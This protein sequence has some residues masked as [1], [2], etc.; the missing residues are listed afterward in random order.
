M[1][2][3]TAGAGTPPTPKRL[4]DDRS[5]PSTEFHRSLLVAHFQ[6]LRA[7]LMERQAAG[8]IIWK[9]SVALCRY[10]TEFPVDRAFYQAGMDCK[11]AGNI[12]M[13]FFFLN[14]YLDIADAIEDPEN[15]AIDGS[16]FLETD[17]PSPY[18]LDLPETHFSSEAQVEDIR[19]FVLQW[20]MDQNVQQTMDTRQCD[21]CKADIYAG[22]L[23][24]PKCNCKHE[25]CVVTGYPVSKR[26]RVE[27]SNCGAAANRDDWNAY[28]LKSK[29]CPWCVA[30]WLHLC[31]LCSNSSCLLS[32]SGLAISLFARL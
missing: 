14:R 8:D 28:L 18:D 2:I 4:M 3:L 19:D 29:V 30:S 26:S 6:S 31:G 10:C 12:N 20:S 11:N 1:T 25:P 24:C 27:C 15:A 21:S 32:L 22:T 23:V 7:N 5:P 13:A 16:D 9:I 17:I